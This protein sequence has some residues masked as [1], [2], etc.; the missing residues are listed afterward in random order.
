ML[1]RRQSARV[2]DF[3]VIFR[4][5]HCRIRR[6]GMEILQMLQQA[7]RMPDIAGFRVVTSEGKVGVRECRS[8]L[9]EL[10]PRR[11]GCGGV[12]GLHGSDAFHVAVDASRVYARSNQ[13]PRARD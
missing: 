9:Y 12:A 1:R 7:R 3:P 4:E 6:I 2:L 10:L 13:R 8:I 5:L 11:Y